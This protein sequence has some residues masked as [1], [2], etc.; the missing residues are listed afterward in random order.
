MQGIL[1]LHLCEALVCVPMLLLPSVKTASLLGM[2]DFSFSL[3]EKV[4]FTR[5][6]FFGL[7]LD[8]WIAPF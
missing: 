4:T 7:W 2:T 8:G 6:E 5:I 1:L 3:L